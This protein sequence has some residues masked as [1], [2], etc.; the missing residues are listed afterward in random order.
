ML[1]LFVIN[2]TL[3][4]Y[5]VKFSLFVQNWA[6]QSCSSKVAEAM[7]ERHALHPR[8]DLIIV[9]QPLDTIAVYLQEQRQA[10]K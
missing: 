5:L 3:L 2:S 8:Q 1:P 7:L 4:R 10:E 9:E 6:V